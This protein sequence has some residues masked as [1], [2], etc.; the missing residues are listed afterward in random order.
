[1]QS[2]G[3]QTMDASR[4]QYRAM[5]GTGGVGS[6][7][8]FALENNHTLG[9][10]ES[11]AGRFLARQDYCKLHIIAHYVR[12]LL[13]PKF[14]VIPASKVG[15][16]DI[17]R[18][19]LAE[20]EEVGL[21]LRYMQMDG[22]RPTL[23][24]FCLTYPDGSGGNL[25]ASDAATAAVDLDFINQ[26]EDEFSRWA[27]QAVALAVPEV[28]IAA[29][30]RLLELGTRAQCL[31]V[32]ALTSAEARSESVASLLKNVDLLALNLEEA[33]ALGGAAADQGLAGR[34]SVPGRGAIADRQAGYAAL[35]HGRETGQLVLG[36]RLPH[37][38]ADI[39]SR[40]CRHRR[41]GRCPSGRGHHRPGSR[42]LTAAG[43][44]VRRACRRLFDHLA[45]H[46]LQRAESQGTRRVCRPPSLPAR[47]ASA[48]R[49]LRGINP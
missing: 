13:G 29:R 3:N 18:R 6:G 45:S 20:M 23:F 17:G 31:R 25:T 42:P 4:S 1:M 37:S 28:P 15:A 34:S 46:D 9:R 19:L 49:S 36:R 35:A 8:F 39:S 24:S 16:D 27:G 10:E 44:T 14:A 32:A 43:T 12:V 33:A 7:S 5:I 21:D 26:L 38:H 11:R 30:H 22:D 48:S 2:S 40:G 41:R 47:P